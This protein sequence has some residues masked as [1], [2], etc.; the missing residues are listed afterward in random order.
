L[1]FQRGKSGLPEEPTF[2]E[3]ETS[4]YIIQIDRAMLHSENV[5]EFYPHFGGRIP[6][7]KSLPCQ[8]HA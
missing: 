6:A 8:T 5:V 7:S 1:P 4:G 3:S 2:F